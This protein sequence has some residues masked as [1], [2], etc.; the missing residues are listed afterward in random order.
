MICGAVDS[1]YWSGFVRNTLIL[2]TL[3]SACGP[4]FL[5]FFLFLSRSVALLFSCSC[6]LS[7]VEQER[8]RCISQSLHLT[9]LGQ[10]VADRQWG[11]KQLPYAYLPVCFVGTTP[12][13][14][15]APEI[16]LWC[17]PL[18]PSNNLNVECFSFTV[19]S[20]RLVC[21]GPSMPPPSSL[22][23]ITGNVV[24]VLLYILSGVM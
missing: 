22:G 15:L 24:L 20:Q 13:F 10:D 2:P 5:T 14:K 1:D 9:E 11:Q 3:P 6:L 21:S 18:L 17:L 19:K 8:S 23:V 16:L 4:V 7:E 12:F